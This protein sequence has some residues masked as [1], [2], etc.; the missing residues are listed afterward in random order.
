MK[1]PTL[2]RTVAA[3]AVEAS[4]GSSYG[5]TVGRNRIPY[6]T[7]ASQK[8]SCIAEKIREKLKITHPGFKFT[9]LQINVNPRSMWHVDAGNHGQSVAI[10]LGPFIGGNLCVYG[11][12]MDARVVRL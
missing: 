5:L 1:L 12:P 6:T 8:V 4:K 10:S 7:P 11:G 3:R 9:S 2:K